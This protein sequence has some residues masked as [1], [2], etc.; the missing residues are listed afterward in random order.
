M[1]RAVGIHPATGL[2]A[3]VAGSEL[4]GVWGTLFAAPLAGLVQ[5]I[6]TAAWLE[7]R[8]GAPEEV[9]QAVVRQTTEEADEHTRSVASESA[10]EHARGVASGTQ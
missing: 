8:G 9:F 1:G 6:I 5:A 3:L 2:I 4:F 10:D 7:F